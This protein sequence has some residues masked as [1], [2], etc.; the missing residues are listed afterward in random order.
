MI[1]NK[2]FSKP[3]YDYANAVIECKDGNYMIAGS[4]RSKEFADYDI[5]VLLVD[6]LGNLIWDKYFGEKGRLEFAT[7][8][9]ETSDKNFLICGR[10]ETS[11]YLLKFNSAGS[12][13][14]QK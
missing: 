5:N 1:F 12:I 3:D 9:I 13:I 7:S 4:S 2:V 8:L 6:T 10:K 11:A 14:W